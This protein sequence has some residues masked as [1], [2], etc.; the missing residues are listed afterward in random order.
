MKGHHVYLCP[1]RRLYFVADCGATKHTS[2]CDQ[3]NAIIGNAPRKRQHKATKGNKKIGKIVENGEIIFSVW[4]TT[5]GTTSLPIQFLACYS[6]CVRN[7][8]EIGVS[9]LRC[10]ILCTLWLHHRERSK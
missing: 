7:L 5:H 1:N 2:K 10:F 8:S 3:C 6:N 4:G 9:I